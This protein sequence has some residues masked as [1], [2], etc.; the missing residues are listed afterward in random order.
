MEQDRTLRFAADRS[1]GKLCTW[2]RILGFD[3]LCEADF[4]GD[5]FETLGERILVTRIH[6]YRQ[7]RRNHPL[8]FIH[9]DRVRD[10]LRQVIESVPL[11]R[12]DLCLFSRCIRCNIPL[13][14]A[15][16]SNLFGRV[17]EYIWQTR[18]RFKECTE[19]G[20]IYWRGT[21]K[22]AADMEIDR[23]FRRSTGPER[24]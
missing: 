17:P 15:D 18:D 2:L 24:A 3:T 20:R 9:R 14:P 16:K 12:I 7:R 4:C 19:C 6:E 10:Q 13:R 23:L 22:D 11:S 21:H 5:F 1:L 8:I